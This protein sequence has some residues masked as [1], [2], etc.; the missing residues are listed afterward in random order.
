MNQ[1]DA[2]KLLEISAQ[3]AIEALHIKASTEGNL[4]SPSSLL[5]PDDVLENDIPPPYPEAAPQWNTEWQEKKRQIYTGDW[6]P[7]YGDAG[8]RA[9]EVVNSANQTLWRSS[10]LLKAS[11]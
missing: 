10:V 3:L 9:R 4:P 7:G 6:A 8:M 5:S 1:P 11:D 2:L